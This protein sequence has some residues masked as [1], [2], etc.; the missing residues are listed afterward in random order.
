[1]AG[2][3][4]QVSVQCLGWECPGWPGV[5]VPPPRLGHRPHS[6]SFQC[7]P[8]PA[9]LQRV[10]VGVWAASEGSARPGPACLQGDAGTGI[11]AGAV[12]RHVTV[13]GTVGQTVTH[14]AWNGFSAVTAP[15]PQLGLGGGC[16]SCWKML[17][18]C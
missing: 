17:P 7:V 9:L 15:L 12:S 14:A 16:S 1:M 18:K 10:P 3:A 13:Q 4:Q 6:V 2:V 5:S 8:C 11:S